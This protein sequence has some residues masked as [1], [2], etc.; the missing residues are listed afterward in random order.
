MRVSGSI[1]G[2]ANFEIKGH[3]VWCITKCKILSPISS[4]VKIKHTQLAA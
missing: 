1:Q 4:T 2:G 3:R